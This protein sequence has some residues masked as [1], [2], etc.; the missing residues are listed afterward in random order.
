M[1]R[2]LALFIL[3]S[4]VVGSC[5]C[6]NDGDSDASDD[7]VSDDDTSDDDSVDDDQTPDD[8]STDDDSID[9]DTTDDDTSGW[10]DHT[11]P[12]VGWVATGE[13]VPPYGATWTKLYQIDEEGAVEVASPGDS[14]FFN[15]SLPTNDVGWVLNYDEGTNKLYRLESGTWTLMDPQPPCPAY[16]SVH[17][18][19]QG[20]RAFADGT[21]YVVCQGAYLLAWDGSEWTSH[22]L[23]AYEPGNWIYGVGID[24]LSWNECVVWNDQGVYWWDGGSFETESLTCTYQV[25]MQSSD[26]AYRIY[27]EGCGYETASIDVRRDGDWERED[28]HFPAEFNDTATMARIDEHHTAF[29][30]LDSGVDR[31]SVILRD[32]GVE[33]SHSW[34]ATPWWMDFGASGG[35]LAVSLPEVV[36]MRLV[37]Q[38]AET[39][40]A[41]ELPA[42]P[43]LVLAADA[44]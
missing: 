11:K 41:I 36:L 14:P 12:V 4:F 13:A 7:D 30:Y 8:D 24:C 19:M 44:E 39:L 6:E 32:D 31:I 5:G 38:A 18:E 16:G 3:F 28:E 23:P 35:G 15:G 34:G 27:T 26:L 33:M 20:V 42:V 29:A 21:G 43:F 9:D 37:G 25:L 2:I 22:E 40:F 1:K 10:P 17:P